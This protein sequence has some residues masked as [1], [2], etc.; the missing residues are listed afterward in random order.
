MHA[1]K[2]I[3][4]HACVDE[5]IEDNGQIDVTIIKDI[6]V[7]P[8]EQKDGSVMVD[9][10]EGKL[11]PLFSQNDKDGVHEIPNLCEIK[12]PQE[13]SHCRR[14]SAVSNTWGEGVSVTVSNEDTFDCHVSTK[15][16]LRHIVEELDWVRVNGREKLH[17][18]RT[19]CDK[20]NVG[21]CDVECR[22]E[23]CQPP[24]LKIKNESHEQ[25][26]AR[27]ERVVRFGYFRNSKSSHYLEQWLFFLPQI[28][29]PWPNGYRYDHSYR[30]TTSVP[31]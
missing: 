17:D 27:T 23:I 1:D 10:K 20:R 6:R 18:L 28:I 25:Q 21:E 14:I 16:D 7:K 2:V 8:V 4:V 11:S 31:W 19:N 26:K 24:T 22:W 5:S 29:V 9:M 13:V 12:Q 15:H 30:H 3:R